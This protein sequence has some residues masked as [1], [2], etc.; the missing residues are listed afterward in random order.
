MVVYG[1]LKYYPDLSERILPLWCCI[2][3]LLLLDPLCLELSVG[4][5]LALAGVKQRVSL[6]HAYQ[7]ALCPLHTHPQAPC[8][9]F[10][11]AACGR[12]AAALVRDN[13]KRCSWVCPKRGGVS[14]ALEAG[15]GG[16]ILTGSYN[17]AR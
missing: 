15:L 12:T 14:E 10:A 2:A 6:Q 4:G 17:K 16:R 5:A 8:L 1:P 3:W 7:M 9:F 13:W 11:L